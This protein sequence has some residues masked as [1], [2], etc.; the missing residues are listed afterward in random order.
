MLVYDSLGSYYGLLFCMWD[1]IGLVAGTVLC[2]GVSTWI[3][4]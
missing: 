2:A 1:G 3:D 4:W